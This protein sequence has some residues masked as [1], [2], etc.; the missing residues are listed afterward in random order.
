VQNSGAGTHRIV[1]QGVEKLHVTDYQEDSL[2]VL[3]VTFILAVPI[4]R[5][6]IPR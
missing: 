3:K 1:I 4:T 5:S 2:I 6:I